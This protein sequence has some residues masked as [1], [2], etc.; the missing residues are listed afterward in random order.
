MSPPEARKTTL[1]EHRTQNDTE[2]LRHEDETGPL[3]AASLGLAGLAVLGAICCIAPMGL[4]LLGLGG[5]WL[6]VFGKLAAFAY[7]LIAL[8]AVVTGLAWVIALGRGASART[9]L[10]LSI[11][12]GLTLI[13]WP[14]AF[15]EGSINDYFI[16][17][18]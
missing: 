16:T 17:L 4:M 1:T 8:S 12:T 11:A 2:T 13:A 5:A 7:Y 6:G 18:M 3:P 9:R 14:V 15:F 10:L